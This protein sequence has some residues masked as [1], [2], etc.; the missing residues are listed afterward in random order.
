MLRRL[1]TLATCCVALAVLVI[2]CDSATSTSDTTAISASLTPTTSADDAVTS[3][4]MTSAET[5]PVEIVEGLVL[6]QVDGKKPRVVLETADGEIALTP[7][8]AQLVGTAVSRAGYSLRSPELREEVPTA[9]GPYCRPAPEYGY[10]TLP[11]GGA[12]Y[13]CPLPPPM[14]EFYEIHL[15]ATPVEELP[16]E[17]ELT[18]VPGGFVGEPR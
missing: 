10:V 18:R 5:Q 14:P 8:Q 2:G 1:P 6:R 15:G 3:K 9:S 17:D 12:L 4:A 13:S 7:Q 11:G 16:P